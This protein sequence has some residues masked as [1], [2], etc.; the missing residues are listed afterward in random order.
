MFTRHFL[1]AAGGVVVLAISTPSAS[2]QALSALKPKEHDTVGFSQ[3]A[4]ASPCR[5]PRPIG[6]LI[7]PNLV[8]A[9]ALWGRRFLVE[10]EYMMA[11]DLRRDLEQVGAEVLGPMP[12]VANALK[13]L[14]Q[15][16]A[17]D[18]AILDINLRGEKAY[19]VADALRERGVP[20]VL[21]TG[22][23]PWA[24]PEA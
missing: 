21:A 1:M 19:P 10:D 4:C 24:L 17:L 2:A 20:F 16:D 8:S 12:R 23:E 22:Y 18:G 5:S 3:P 14:A 6:K 7:V 15:A 11:E 9:S 13:L